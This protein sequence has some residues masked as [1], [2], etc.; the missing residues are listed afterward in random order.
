VDFKITRYSGLQWSVPS[1][2]SRKTVSEYSGFKFLG[3]SSILEFLELCVPDHYI[4][5]DVLVPASLDGGYLEA[6]HPV[7]L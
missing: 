6:D 5:V 4:G 7:L 2:H 3:I 1:G